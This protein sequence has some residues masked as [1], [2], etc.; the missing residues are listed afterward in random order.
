MRHRPGWLIAGMTT[1][2][3]QIGR[4]LLAKQDIGLNIARIADALD[5]AYP[6]PPSAREQAERKQAD[7]MEQAQRDAA[8]KAVFDREVTITPRALGRML[9]AEYPELF[10]THEQAC[11]YFHRMRQ[12]GRIQAKLD[13]S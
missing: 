2:D 4:M 3:E 10:A 11:A 13:L 8:V 9:A 1:N 5:R 7:A 12:A 6:K